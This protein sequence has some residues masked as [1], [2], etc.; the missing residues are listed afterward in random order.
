MSRL[1]DLHPQNAQIS[2]FNISSGLP[3]AQAS[4]FDRLHDL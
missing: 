1:V 4:G 3:N 2:C